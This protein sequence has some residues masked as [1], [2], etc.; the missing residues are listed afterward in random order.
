[1]LD[2]KRLSENWHQLSF[3]S[4]TKVVGGERAVSPKCLLMQT[5]GHLQVHSRD[6]LSSGD[7]RTLSRIFVGDP[8]RYHVRSQSLCKLNI[9]RLVR[10]HMHATG[11]DQASRKTPLLIL[12]QRVPVK[13]RG[14]V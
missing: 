9:T 8:P 4:A 13:A 5:R 14:F 7:L 3:L 10:A 6:W 2:R 1:M 11:S 12:L